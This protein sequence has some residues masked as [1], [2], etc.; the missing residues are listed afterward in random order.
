MFLKLLISLAKYWPLKRSHWLML[1]PAI[2][3]NACFPHSH[4]KG[5]DLDH[6]SPFS[7]DPLTPVENKGAEGQEML[8][9]SLTL[10]EVWPFLKG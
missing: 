7:R 10:G 8:W 3:E 2:D 9:V 1:P 4:V 5:S 6:R